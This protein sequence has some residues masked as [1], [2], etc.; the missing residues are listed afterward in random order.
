MAVIINEL[1][2]VVEAPESEAA[3]PGP[4]EAPPPLEGTL[5]ALTPMDLVDLLEHRRHIELR[6]W[7]H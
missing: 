5:A 3:A 4:A 2:V 6:L 7:A 1:E